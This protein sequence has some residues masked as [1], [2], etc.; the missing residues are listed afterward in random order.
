MTYRDGLSG[1][2]GAGVGSRVKTWTSTNNFRVKIKLIE[3]GSNLAWEMKFVVTPAFSAPRRTARCILMSYDKAQAVRE[4]NHWSG[5]YDRSILQRLLFTPSHR[6]LISRI[7]AW[8]GDRP[9]NVLDVGCGTGVFA[10]RVREALP[11]ARV[12]GVDLVA[13]MLTQG[14]ARWRSEPGRL[15]AVQ[16]DSE[17]LPFADGTFDVV[18][19]SNS[20]H[21][22]P[23]Q[24]RAVVEMRRVL[25]PGGRLLLV[26]GRRDGPWGWFIYDVC[27]T[28]V[29]G[30]VRHASAHRIRD[31]FDRAGFAA[32]VQSVYH[33][34]APFLLS[35]GVVPSGTIQ[36]SRAGVGI[37]EPALTGLVSW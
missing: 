31:L 34:L 19:C 3:N 8:A 28:A 22:Y 24:D 35:E 16:A 21:H 18:T 30:D 15:A 25:R 12:W 9:L 32:T 2:D 36:G 33:G 20:F 27:V 37:S 23:H 5:G 7:V 10:S 17:R 11:R 14:G 29:E 1:G 26:D 6:A 4:F 13:A